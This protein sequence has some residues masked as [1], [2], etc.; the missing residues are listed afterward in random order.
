MLKI[1]VLIFAIGALGGL[2]MATR[3]LTGRLAP[4]AVSLLHAALGATG[5]VLTAI[6]V[7]GGTADVASIV[8]IALVILVVAALGGFFLVSFH[9]RKQLPPRAV[10]FIHAGLAVAGFLLLLGGSFHF[11]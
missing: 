10:V 9:A 5:L 6:V 11:I 4:W 1:A 3:V 8:P 7:L 2:F